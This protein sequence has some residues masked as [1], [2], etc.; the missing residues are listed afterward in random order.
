MSHLTELAG[1][2]SLFI[3]TRLQDLKINPDINLYPSVD[4]QEE[5]ACI[6]FLKQPVNKCVLGSGL[7]TSP[8][9]IHGARDAE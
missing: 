2:S 6:A 4:Q 5:L 7:Q 3:Y 8:S 9:S 1:S